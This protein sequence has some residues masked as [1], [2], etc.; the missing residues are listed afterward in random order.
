MLRHERA[1]RQILILNLLQRDATVRN[2]CLCSGTM[3]Q[4]KDSNLGPG[5]TTAQSWQVLQ[6]VQML[7]KRHLCITGG[8]GSDEEPQEK[9]ISI[10]RPLTYLAPLPE[11]YCSHI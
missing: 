2:W 6:L 7:W 9:C 1:M 3:S 5:N 11:R 4:S 10:H 8:Y